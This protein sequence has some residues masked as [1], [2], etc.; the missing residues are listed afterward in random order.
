V[1]G[2][3]LTFAEIDLWF[4]SYMVLEWRHEVPLGTSKIGDGKEEADR[5]DAAEGSQ[6]APDI[7]SYF[8]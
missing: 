6:I 3:P 7:R 2:N 8:T 1:P 4:L 5:V